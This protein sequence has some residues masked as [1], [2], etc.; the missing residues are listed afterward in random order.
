MRRLRK[1][2]LAMCRC[3]PSLSEYTKLSVTQQPTSRD[4]PHHKIIWTRN[5]R[6]VRSP[7]SHWA[8]PFWAP[9]SLISLNCLTSPRQTIPQLTRRL[10]RVPQG[11]PRWQ[12]IRRRA[13]GSIVLPARRRPHRHHDN[14]RT[15]DLLRH[16][17]QCHRHHGNC[18][19]RDQGDSARRHRRP[20]LAR[21]L[22]AA[23]PQWVV[24]Q[25]AAESAVGIRGESRRPSQVCIRPSRASWHCRSASP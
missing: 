8:P 9:R 12:S 2:R 10:S 16:Q 14:D 1:W 21:T 5:L 7:R 20:A 22:S 13:G 24:Q 3:F 11:A 18:H 17:R 15:A 4:L 23:E 25:P 19:H 6:R